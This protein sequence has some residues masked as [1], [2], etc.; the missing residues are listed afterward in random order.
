MR[1]L[2]LLC[3]SRLDRTVPYSGS[4]FGGGGGGPTRADINKYTQEYSRRRLYCLS[5]VAHVSPRVLKAIGRA[6][7]N[8][9]ESATHARASLTWMV[10]L[11]VIRH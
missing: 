3:A 9:A 1:E 2:Y 4:A 10:T 8:D 6:D 5:S 11:T 7:V